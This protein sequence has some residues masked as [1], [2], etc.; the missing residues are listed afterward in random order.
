MGD[1]RDA[2]HVYRIGADHLLMGATP[3]KHPRTVGKEGSGI[4]TRWRLRPL[5]V[6]IH[7]Y[8][9]VSI[10]T[11]VAIAAL[12]GCPLAFNTE[13]E[14]FFSPQLFA[15]RRAPESRLSLAE[16]AD[17]T[18][19]IVPKG[20][21]LQVTYTEPDQAAVYI[22]PRTNSAT[23]QLEDLGFDEFFVNPWTG[24][25][26]GRRRRGDL[27]EGRINVM[28]FLY[29]VHWR[30]AAGHSGQQ[31]MGFSALLWFLDC[32]VGFALT[33]PTTCTAFFS[34]WK[35]AWCVEWNAGRFRRIFDFHRAVG[36]WLWAVLLIFAW[37][38]VMMNL[39]PV[40]DPTMSLLFDYQPEIPLPRHSV[41]TPR[42]DWKAAETAGRRWIA[43]EATRRRFTA[44]PPQSLMY[45]P[46]SNTYS[47]MIHG[48]RDVFE[49]SPKG[50]GTYVDFDAD[51]GALLQCVEPTG[52]HSG[53]TVE[54]WLYALHMT[55][56]FGHPY[57]WFVAGFGVATASMAITGLWLWLRKL[58]NRS[59]T[60][61]WQLAQR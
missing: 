30:L 49:R 42:L 31:V 37:S 56:V 47:Y 7:R 50:G 17:K 18:Q 19:L 32:F 43:L 11:F 57:Q 14:R 26:L 45:D 28:P 24:T 61:A 33:L 51:T 36:L 29:E 6:R 12:T 60:S 59:R 40:F 54:S 38:A 58:R 46:D 15:P 25:E 13:L 20:R 55:R 39:R 10:A 4:S 9:G 44:G 2:T 27:F 16:L 41:A 1:L 5:L 53:N 35:I 52:R 48:S 21:V 23:G 34:R 8:I 3:Q 22:V